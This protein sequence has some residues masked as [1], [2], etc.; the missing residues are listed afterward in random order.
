MTTRR[1]TSCPL[2]YKP[3]A[4]SPNSDHAP[5]RMCRLGSP[6]NNSGIISGISNL[7]EACTNSIGENKGETNGSS[8]KKQQRRERN[9]MGRTP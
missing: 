4:R 6:E 3:A 5:F 7:H 1:G 8:E 2:A 9:E